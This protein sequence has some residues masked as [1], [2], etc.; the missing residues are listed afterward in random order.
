MV[1][2]PDDQGCC[3]FGPAVDFL[4]ELWPSIPLRFG[5]I[6]PLLPRTR[7]AARIPFEAFEYSVERAAPISGFSP[8]G[9]DAVTGRRR[10]ETRAEQ[11]QA[12]VE[13]IDP[14]TGEITPG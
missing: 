5:H 14:D 13:I 7:G 12:T 6:N 8:D 2:P 9:S 4:V 1:S 3:S 11:N 10:A